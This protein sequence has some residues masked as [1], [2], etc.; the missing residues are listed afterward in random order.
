MPQFSIDERIA[1]WLLWLT[2]L[3]APR[4]SDNSYLEGAFAP[5]HE[6]HEFTDLKV[7]GEI[8]DE[9]NGL[10][11]RIGPN[12]IEVP[13]PAIHH[14]FIGDGM[15]HGLRLGEGGAQ[16]Y[17]NRWV[18]TDGVQKHLGKPE[19]P[20]LRKGGTRV[21]NTNVIGHAG[22]VW[23]LV[24]AGNLPVEMTAE[25]ES[26]RH[27][28]FDS[29]E[30][31]SFTAHPHCDPATGELHA[32]CYDALKI[33]RIYYLVI[34][35]QGQLTRRVDIPVKHGPMVH[36]CAV[37]A[38]QTVVLDLPVTFS[39]L[40]MLKGTTFPYHWNKRHPARV[41]LLGR[42]AEASE[43]RWFNVEPC[44][45]F[46]T[47]NAYDRDDGAVVVDVIVH[48][49]M[50][51]RSRVGP[52][53]DRITLERWVLDPQKSDVQRQVISELHQEFP[54]FDERLATQPYRYT[55]SVGFE[56]IHPNTPMPLYRHDMIE[57]G[58]MEHD[59]GPH[60]V[61]SEPVFI[62]RKSAG[63]E[64]DGWVIASLYDLEKDL[65]SVAILNADDFA[66]EPQA[67]IDLPVRAP[68]GFHGNWIPS[69]IRPASGQ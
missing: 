45:V 33:D 63:D 1:N 32:I 2:Q 27:G 43:I 66:G 56:S 57:G 47:S 36:D 60:K 3:W 22:R 31:L 50:F 28:L 25:L 53:S 41:G 64:T 68:L 19:L 14:W 18:G 40:T 69:D 34:D 49:T 21:V 37:T 58:V 9:L 54:R 65:S 15:V 17:R 44:Y 23:A 8:P 39:I 11:A 46:H 26:V 24:E 6:E 7:T 16:W 5:V 61:C 30:R 51:D 35:R 67:I 4:S 38:K 12:P 20:G 10:Y 42:N 13:N 52:D 62:P 59:F 29:D 55:Y 48:A